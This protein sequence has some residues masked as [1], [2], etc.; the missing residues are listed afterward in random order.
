MVRVR[1]KLSVKEACAEEIA[2]EGPQLGM[3]AKARKFGNLKEKVLFLQDFILLK[4]KLVHT[5]LFIKSPKF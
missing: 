1:F 5:I 4:K 3:L 2:T